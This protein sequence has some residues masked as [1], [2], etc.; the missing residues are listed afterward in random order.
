M[1]ENALKCARRVERL[2]HT[3]VT[4]FL[5][6]TRIYIFIQ[7]KTAECKSKRYKIKTCGCEQSS[8]ASIKI[9]RDSCNTWTNGMHSPRWKET[10]WVN[11]RSLLW[12]YTYIPP[13]R[14]QNM[15][16]NKRKLIKSIK[17]KTKNLSFTNNS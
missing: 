10:P 1:R 8:S 15:R 13:L 12:D 7:N 14:T 6:S 11:G 17:I 2:E 4:N 16:R 5:L 9:N 3:S